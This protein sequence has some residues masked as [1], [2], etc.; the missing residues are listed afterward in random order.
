MLC[1]FIFRLLYD[2]ISLIFEEQTKK[3]I[4]DRRISSN[5]EKLRNENKKIV[6]CNEGVKSN[7]GGNMRLAG[8]REEG[9]RLED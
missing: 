4:Q 8:T 3:K 5:W 6:P 2:K 7:Q 1:N 9:R